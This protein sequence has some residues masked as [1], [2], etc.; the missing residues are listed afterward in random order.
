MKTLV[1]SPVEIKLY[2]LNSRFYDA[3]TGR[4]ISPDSIEFLNSDKIH[5]LNLYVYC[6][7]NPVMYSDGS[8]HFAISTFLISLAVGSLVSWGLSEIF[9]VQIAGGIGSVVG[10]GTAVST[11]ISLLAFGPVGWIAG[12]AVIL[13]GAGSMSFG[14][15]EIIAGATGTNYIQQWTGMSDELYN[16]LYIGLNVAST[17]GTIVYEL[18]NYFRQQSGNKR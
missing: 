2:Y 15:N 9:G 18:C 10:G 1:S 3:E 7:N 4:F 8:G 17:V 12:V 11:G 6:F 13:I 16:G 14:V 5:G